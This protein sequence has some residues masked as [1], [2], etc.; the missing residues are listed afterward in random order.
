M[1]YD[2]LSLVVKYMRQQDIYRLL[3]VG[4]LCKHLDLVDT[5]ENQ[6]IEKRCLVDRLCFT[7][8]TRQDIVSILKLFEMYKHKLKPIYTGY[9]YDITYQYR[10]LAVTVHMRPQVSLLVDYMSVYNYLTRRRM[11]IKCDMHEQDE[12]NLESME[13]IINKYKSD[14]DYLNLT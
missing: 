1:N 10:Y 13:N 12:P 14:N 11:C 9:M 8:S 7:A 2:N 4:P 3:Q 5:I 6:T